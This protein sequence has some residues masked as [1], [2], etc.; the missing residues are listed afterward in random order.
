MESLKT[1]Y[2][3]LAVHDCV[4]ML[5]NLVDLDDAYPILKKKYPSLSRR[6]F[7]K[8]FK[9]MLGISA[10]SYLANARRV[11]ALSML[12]QW[13]NFP[14][15]RTK[16]ALRIGC[17]RSAVNSLVFRAGA[18]NV[19]ARQITYRLKPIEDCD[20]TIFD[21]NGRLRERTDLL[22]ELYRS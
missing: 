17:T 16:I 10:K 11:F 7:Q 2:L 15:T 18:T 13:G 9:L 22:K 21:Q 1:N 20:D 4:K 14:E 6:A 3:H 8:K 5:D 19:C 12:R